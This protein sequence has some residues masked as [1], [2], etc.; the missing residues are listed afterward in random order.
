M[1]R[2]L[3]VTAEVPDRDLGGGNIR[4]HHLLAAVAAAHDVDLLLAGSLRDDDLRRSLAGVTEVE[5][6]PPFA[7]PGGR[8]ARRWAE[9]TAGL[10]RRD[11]FEV[12]VEGASRSR[13]AAALPVQGY[14]VT[15]VQHAALAPLAPPPARRGGAWV[16]ELHNLAS[17]RSAQMAAVAGHGRHRWMWQRDARRAARLERWIAQRYDAVVVCSDDDASGFAGDAVVVPNGVDTE[18]FVPAP[19]PADPRLVLTASFNYPPNVE[20]AVWF[21]DEVLPLVRAAVP[22]ATLALVGREPVPAVR[23]LAG[24]EGVQGCFDVPAVAPHLADARVAVVPLRVGTGTRLKALEAM[25]AGRPLA[26]TAIGLAGLELEPGA[27]A[28]VADRPEDLAAGIVGLLTDDALAAAMAGAG[29]ALAEERYG[30]PA[31]GAAY[32]EALEAVAA[33]TRA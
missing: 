29:R 17:A 30:W 31:L 32:V 22:G 3:W 21:C 18:R 6:G 16:S 19:L 7:W 10:P 13:L 12:V 28:V 33:R 5:P 24:R 11:P 25:A 4:Q 23:A 2:V 20:G 1:V 14:D 9:L 26:G 15:V 27:S 8:W